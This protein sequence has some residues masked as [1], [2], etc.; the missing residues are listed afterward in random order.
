M[1]SAAGPN[2]PA[3]HLPSGTVTML[4]TDVESSTSLATRLRERY[5]DVL[6]EHRRLL[7]DAVTAHGDE[8]FAVF[9]RARDAVAASA[10]AQVALA[11]H[12]WPVEAPLRVRMGVHTGEPT[13]R[14]GSYVGVEVHRAARICAAGRGGQV[15]VSSTTA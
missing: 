8:L 12:P 1:S 6:A 14:E 7:R 4:F 15:L 2:H 3:A 9:T 11:A 10:A 5:G 13:L